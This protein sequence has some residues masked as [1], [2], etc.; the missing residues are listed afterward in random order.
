MAVVEYMVEDGRTLAWVVR[1]EGT[2][3]EILPEKRQRLEAL[4]TAWRRALGRSGE[5][6][7]RRR[8]SALYAVLVKPLKR[9][10]RPDDALVIVPDGPLQGIPF[11]ALASPETGRRLV[12]AWPVRLAPSLN[13]L[14]ACLQQAARRPLPPAP[15]V[16]VIAEPKVDPRLFPNLP[17]LRF[18]LEE[19]REVSR[20]WGA[21]V[22]SGG[23]A[24][25]DRILEEIGR[26]DVVQF[27]G[28]TERHRENPLLSAFVV[29][30]DSRDGS[31][32]YA[33]ELLGRRFER[34][35]L[36]VLSACSTAAG[37]NSPTEGSLSLASPFL[38]AG[39]PTV[40]ASLW[41]VEDRAS[42][43]LM[44]AFHRHLRQGKPPAAAF[45][46]AQLEMLASPDP[47]LR[48]PR[49]WASFA[50]V[51]GE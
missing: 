46:A 42:A 40:I 20:L 45:H 25:K 34:T 5:N 23:E 11:A 43:S 24:T 36:V 29:T 8:A 26:Y 32:L 12:E 7:E 47:D 41:D 4:V 9:H 37:T 31:L 6:E 30:A 21:R 16:L 28:H 1:R 13:V 14:A 33:Y 44:T 18:A 19:A 3:L 49:A 39:A 38:A 15:S 48:A 50:F 2:V 51:G 22:L 10:L 27:A 35:R 17:P